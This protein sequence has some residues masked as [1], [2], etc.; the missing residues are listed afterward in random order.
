M[1]VNSQYLSTIEQ[2]HIVLGYGSLMRKDSRE[3][4]SQIYTQ[5]LP[6]TVSGYER[7][8]VTRS[9]DERQT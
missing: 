2:K 1:T 4:Y 3:R 7:A 5:G 9:L 6:V 8:W